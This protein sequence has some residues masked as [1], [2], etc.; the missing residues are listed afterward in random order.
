MNRVMSFCATVVLAALPAALL[1]QTAEPTPPPGPPP[2]GRL[3]WGL[4]FLGGMPTGTFGDIVGAGAG[5]SGHLVLTAPGKSFGVRLETSFLEYGSESFEVPFAG[6]HGRVS[7]DLNTSNEIDR[8]AMGPQVMARHG[9]F[10][11]YAYVTV[12][13]AYFA[14]VSTVISQGGGSYDDDY[15]YGVLA[16]TTNFSDTTLSLAA[17]GGVQYALNPRVFL[18]LGLRY[19]AN[20]NVGWLAEGDLVDD[21]QGGARPR[22]HYGKT[23]LVEFTVGVSFGR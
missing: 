8:F 17:G 4:G 12:G 21:G 5:F 20:G 6:T 7:L 19:V 23:S 11:P 18:D 10:R 1:A 16:T 14:T 13:A 3:M 22:P 9:S 2:P 15:D